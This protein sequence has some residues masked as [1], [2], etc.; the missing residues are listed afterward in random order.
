MLPGVEDELRECPYQQEIGD[1]PP[2]VVERLPASNER[3]TDGDESEGARQEGDA[4]D[5]GPRIP[6]A[7]CSRK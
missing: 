1:E 3:D 7:A 2:T 6:Q 4:K 5:A